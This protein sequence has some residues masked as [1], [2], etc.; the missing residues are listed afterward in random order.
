MKIELIKFKI[1]DIFDGYTDLNEEGV[2]AYKGKLNIRPKY[3]REFVYKDTKR[4]EVIHTINKNFPLNVMYWVKNK[5]DTYE[6]LDGQQRTIS[7][8]QY[9]N[10]DFS[11]NSFYFHNL[12]QYEKDKILNYEIN[13][14]ICAGNDKEILQWF[15]IIN[16]AGEKLEKQELRNAVYTGQWLTNAKKIFSKTNCPAFFKAKDYLSGKAIRQNYLETC[17]KWISS[18]DSISI[19]DYMA[20]HQYDNDAQELWTYFQNVINWVE[21]NF[22]NKREYMKGLDWGLFY[23]KYKNNKLNPL[24]IEEDIKKLIKDDEVQN[25]K[26]IYEYILSGEKK[27]L[28]LR[29][30]KIEDGDRKFEEQNGICVLCEKKFERNEMQMD[31]I[32]PWSKNGKTTY[33]NL[34]MLCEKCNKSKSN[35]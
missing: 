32:I 27:I 19:E 6:V 14:Y 15:E 21:I 34:Q 9:C 26:G 11:I 17:L 16:I 23:N 30:F 3:Q 18:I 10:G 2:F 33:E 31:H 20:K 13:V 24:I 35:N 7:F 12:T 1:K 8:C 5:S 25:K 22:T 28:N 4:N 29:T